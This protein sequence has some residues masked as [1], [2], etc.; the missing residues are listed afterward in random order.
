MALLGVLAGIFGPMDAV[1]FFS[2]P[3]LV[4]GFALFPR[5]TGRVYATLPV[6]RKSLGGAFWWLCVVGVPAVAA[7]ASVP[8]SV[9]YALVGEGG[10]F[11][12]YSIRYFVCL[13]TF[14]GALWFVGCACNRWVPVQFRNAPTGALLCVACLVGYTFLIDT[15][16]F[17]QGVLAGMKREVVLAVAASATVAGYLIRSDALVTGETVVMKRGRTIAGPRRYWTTLECGWVRVRPFVGTTVTCAAAAL[18]VPLFVLSIDDWGILD[19]AVV[20][21]LA[22]LMVLAGGA[23]L[24]D[25]L[26]LR[27]LPFSGRRLAA[28]LCVR[29]AL[30]LFATAAVLAPLSEYCFGVGPLRVVAVLVAV[31]GIS[32]I[33][34]S[35]SFA[36]GWEKSDTLAGVGCAVAFLAGVLFL[37]VPIPVLFPLG[38]VG[39]AYGFN[40][41]HHAITHESSPYVRIRHL[42]LFDEE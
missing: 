38:A 33:F 22:A 31:F 35:Y 3:V 17:A 24:P 19:T 5:G 32:P 36:A 9:V 20:P 13:M 27:T 23:N 42:G 29:P 11:G 39:A 21:A 15:L 28:F 41:V 30:A 25:V 8:F 26:S 7:A 2:V 16:P 34:V 6:S 40:R 14:A 10:P 1:L 12:L 18:F 37:F 4:C